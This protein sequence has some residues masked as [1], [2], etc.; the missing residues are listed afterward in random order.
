V[1]PVLHEYDTPPDAVSVTVAGVQKVV[2]PDGVMAAVGLALTVTV[3]L[4][5]ALHPE[6][7]VAVTV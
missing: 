5:V 7:L 3:P 1:A 2:A 6:A 4:A